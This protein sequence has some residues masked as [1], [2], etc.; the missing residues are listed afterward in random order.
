[1]T[2]WEPY[3]TFASTTATL[4]LLCIITAA[5]L[6]FNKKER[7]RYSI[8]RSFVGDYIGLEHKPGVR[9]LLERREYV[10]FS[11]TVVK[12]DRRFKVSSCCCCCSFCGSCSCSSNSKLGICTLLKRKECVE[13]LDTIIKFDRRFKG[14][15][16]R[17]CLL[18]LKKIS[19]R[20]LGP[21]DWSSYSPS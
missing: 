2:R 8:N 6:L 11:D 21:L 3:L 16:S 13:F 1:M 5:S 14:S 12:Y 4:V 9:A 7:R 10:E 19:C 15:G 18:V 17:S 20:Q